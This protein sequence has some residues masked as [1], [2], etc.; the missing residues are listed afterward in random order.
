MT[1]H[2]NGGRTEDRGPTTH[3]D[4][5]DPGLDNLAERILY[6][7]AS[8]R[9]VDPDELT[10]LRTGVDP[11]A[12]NALFDPTGSGYGVRDGELVFRYEGFE[13]TVT[14]DGGI[15]LRPVDDGG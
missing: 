6:D 1:D 5:F 7:V 10:P 4:Q 14:S 11:D 3:R 13:V 15:E 12:L 9:G 8:L 2:P